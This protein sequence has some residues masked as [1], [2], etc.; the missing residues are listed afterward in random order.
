MWPLIKTRGSF[1]RSKMLR[2]SEY[3][4][5]GIMGSGEMGQWLIAKI[6]LDRDVK[7]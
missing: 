5:D 1:K 7:K 4:S 6:T 3:W 2:I